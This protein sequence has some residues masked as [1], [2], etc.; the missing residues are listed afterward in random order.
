MSILSEMKTDNAETKKHVQN[1][2]TSVNIGLV[3]LLVGIAAIVAAFF[4]VN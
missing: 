2:V 1:L 4:L 3:G